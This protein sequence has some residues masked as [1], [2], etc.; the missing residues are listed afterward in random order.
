MD[1][2]FAF[3]VV[4]ALLIVNMCVAYNMRVRKLLGHFLVGYASLFLYGY[5]TFAVNDEATIDSHIVSAITMFTTGFLAGLL[6]L[7]TGAPSSTSIIPVV[8][9]LAPGSTAVRI[10]LK[11]MQLSGSVTDA[12]LGLGIWDNLILQCVSFAVGL[13]LSLEML[14]PALRYKREFRAAIIKTV[15]TVT[16]QHGPSKS[17]DGIESLSIERS[18]A[19]QMG[20]VRSI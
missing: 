1:W 12:V 3:G 14:K 17:P 8:L 9:I 10:S 11:D 5:L 16:P 7:L 13:F 4:N 2:K 6:E 15:E 19:M 18:S 20:D